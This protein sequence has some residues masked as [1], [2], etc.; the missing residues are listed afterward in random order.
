LIAIVQQLVSAIALAWQPDVH[1]TTSIYILYL[2]LPS[3]A[4]LALFLAAA[5]I[6]AI[7]SF[8]AR[9]KVET[10]LLLVPQQFLLFLC[11]G[12][13]IHA[14]AVG[15]F[16]DGTQRSSMF[17]LADQVP[18]ILIAVFHSWAMVLILIYGEEN[19]W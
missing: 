6:A 18:M 8:S 2:I 15:E 11:A 13:A 7:A 19:K 10:L 3:D 16:A 12:A 9:K 17:L 4:S 1:Y 14:I 5:S